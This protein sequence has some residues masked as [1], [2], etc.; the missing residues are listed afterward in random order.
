MNILSGSTGLCGVGVAAL[1]VAPVVSKSVC[2]RVR[3]CARVNNL[4]PRVRP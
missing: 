3:T 4:H 2:V 1:S